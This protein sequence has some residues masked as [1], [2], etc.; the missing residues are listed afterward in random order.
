MCEKN[1]V[2]KIGIYGG[3]FDPVHLGH[4]HLAKDAV[5]QLSLD[6]L[7]FVPTNYQPF[8]LNKK[9]TSGKDRLAMLKIAIEN[10]DFFEVSS[11]ELD[12]EKI[13]YT[14]HTLDKL[15]EIYQNFELIFLVGTDTFFHMEKWYKADEL[16]RKYSIAVGIRPGDNKNKALAYK[17]YL[18]NK[19]GT[20]IYL[21]N[22]EAFNISATEIRK[23]VSKKENIKKM[24]GESIERYIDERKLYRER[25]K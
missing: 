12:V 20:T 25:I 6:K 9:V 18:Q 11:M 3:S 14:I 8:K 7:I 5:K 17:A 19:Y 10:S 16:L 23:M 13:S 22:N 21:L 24:V 2:K 4:L 1:D 15:K